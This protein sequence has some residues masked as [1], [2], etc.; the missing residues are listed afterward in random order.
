MLA[1]SL[2]NSNAN[3]SRRIDI[4]TLAINSLKKL[5]RDSI[6]D[7]DIEKFKHEYNRIVDD[8]EFRSDID[9]FHTVKARCKEHNV[10]WY[11]PF[12]SNGSK[13]RTQ[14]HNYLSEISP[15]YLQGKI[16]LIW[17]FKALIV[18]LPLLVTLFCFLVKQ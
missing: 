13:D 18:L 14:L 3:Y 4:I 10:K 17:C 7:T 9:F 11:K 1:Y 5:K 2:I 15:F 16:C 12:N 6:I 8:V